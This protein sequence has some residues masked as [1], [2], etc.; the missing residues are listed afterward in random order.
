MFAHLHKEVQYRTSIYNSIRYRNYVKV[1]LGKSRGLLNNQ[2]IGLYRIWHYL[3]HVFLTVS[4][5]WL[6]RLCVELY[7]CLCISFLDL[8]LYKQLFRWIFPIINRHN[9]VYHRLYRMNCEKD[10]N[11]L[12]CMNKDILKD[13]YIIVSLDPF[14]VPYYRCMVN[15]HPYNINPHCYCMHAT[16][17]A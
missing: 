11:I 13:I 15:I 16:E 6:R 17:V 7:S 14:G 12:Q 8:R 10:H 9:H 2:H 1:I 3:N 4:S 5:C